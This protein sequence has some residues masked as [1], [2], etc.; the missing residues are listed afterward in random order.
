VIDGA[1]VAARAVHFTAALLLQGILAF[2]VLVAAPVFGGGEA[3]SAVRSLDRIAVG[4]FLVAILSGAAWLLLLASDLNGSSVGG[5]L[6]DGTAWLLLTQTQFGIAWACRAALFLLLALCMIAATRSRNVGMADAASCLL[7]IAAAG[8]IAWS[9]HGAATP[10]ALG[11]VHTA[12][13][14]LHLVAAGFWL[15]GLLPFLIL[16]PTA[17]AEAARRLTVR[18]SAVASASVLVLLSTGIAIGWFMLPAIG[19]LT[20]TLYGKLLLAKIALFFLMLAFAAVNRFVLTPQLASD[21]SAKRATTRLA[22]H[23]GCEIAL[24]VII[25]AIVGALGIL[26]P[27]AHPHAAATGPNSL[28]TISLIHVL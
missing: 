12:L 16:L 21:A 13:D 17:T 5:A 8:S 1:L 11:N 22:I 9:G 23:S 14:F 15:G 26:D 19:A 28:N 3:R 24:G 27:S 6:A 4:A 18:F 25:L 10:G 2:H 7:S 20:G